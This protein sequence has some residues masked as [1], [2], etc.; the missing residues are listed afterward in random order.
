MLKNLSEAWY[1]QQNVAVLLETI[2]GKDPKWDPSL[3]AFFRRIGIP[4]A[5]TEVIQPA[6]DEGKCLLVAGIRQTPWPPW[7]FG[8]RRILALYQVWLVNDKEAG[9]GNMF[10]LDDDI[11]NIGLQAAVYQETLNQLAE[12]GIQKL[13]HI[14][15]KGAIFAHRVLTENGF[16]ETEDIVL[17]D[18]A[19]YSIYRAS[20]KDHIGRL[21]VEG[22]SS[23]NLLACEINERLYDRIT[24]FLT[25][26]YLGTKAFWKESSNHPEI[27]PANP[28]LV[29][30]GSLVAS[31]H[32]PPGPDPAC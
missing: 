20:L 15:L 8:T 18:H 17:T 10:V 23:V 31:A 32:G 21:G 26:T 13:N 30:A 28:E 5:C 7:G 4:H 6:L 14:V 19:Q 2:A 22:K 9:L 1:T 25:A 11:S 3:F 27:I 16:E 29:A 24:L 12:R